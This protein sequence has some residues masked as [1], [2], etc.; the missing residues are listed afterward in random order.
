LY[1]I[2]TVPGYAPATKSYGPTAEV[3][4]AITSW[5]YHWASLCGI[6]LLTSVPLER[7]INSRKFEDPEG[8]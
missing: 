7:K 2:F 3:S 5:V 8:G 1:F 4:I 6:R